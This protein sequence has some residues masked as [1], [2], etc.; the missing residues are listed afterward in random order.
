V[1]PSR[2]AGRAFRAGLSAS[3]RSPGPALRL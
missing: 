1:I 2:P 3:G